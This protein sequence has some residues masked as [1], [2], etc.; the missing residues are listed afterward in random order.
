[1]ST[2]LPPPSLTISDSCLSWSDQDNEN[3]E[4]DD[5]YETGD[6][7]GDNDDGNNDGE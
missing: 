2:A 7:D 4:V 6:V 1:M 5:K 3:D